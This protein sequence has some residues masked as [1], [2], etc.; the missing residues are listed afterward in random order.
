VRVLYIFPHPD[1][2]S[3]GPS[4][5]IAAQRRQGHEV[6]LLT[7][8]H[9]EATKV[10]HTYGWTLEQMG[11]AR[12]RELMA[13]GRMLDLTGIEILSLP[14]GQLKELDPTRIERGIRDEIMHVQPHVLVTF[15]IH[16]ISGFPD[17]VVTHSAVTRVFVELFGPDRPWLQRLAFF[18][19]VSAPEEFPWHVNVSAASE[20]DCV[21]EVT[22]E[23]MDHFHRALDCYVTYAEVIA[24]TNVHQLFDR[25]VHFELFREDHKPPLDDLTEGLRDV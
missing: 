25:K 20:I 4:R 3:F 18:T 17:H 14:D 19:V 12:Y 13:V 9:G 2:E 10:R 21:L 7:L 5:A 24:R 1:D 22:P 23:D 6:F 11:Q 15:P 8:T 16:G